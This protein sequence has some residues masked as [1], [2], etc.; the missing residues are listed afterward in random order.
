MKM[1]I[2]KH[3]KL[4]KRRNQLDGIFLDIEKT[5]KENKDKLT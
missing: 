4:L 5:L 2:K 1:K 3:A